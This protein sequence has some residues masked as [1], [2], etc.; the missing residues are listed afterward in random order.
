MHTISTSNHSGERDSAFLRDDLLLYYNNRSRH[1]Y[2]LLAVLCRPR[3]SSQAI[4]ASSKK[5][6]SLSMN[7]AVRIGIMSLIAIDIRSNTLHLRISKYDHSDHC[8]ITLCKMCLRVLF[9]HATGPVWQ[10]TV[11]DSNASSH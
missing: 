1:V 9:F 2:F 3:K 7:N 10:R 4:F 11:S 8:A 6:L 5:A